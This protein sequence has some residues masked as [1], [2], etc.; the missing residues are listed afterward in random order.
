MVGAPSQST[1]SSAANRGT[2]RN[3][4]RL[5]LESIWST[6]LLYTS[7]QLSF[8]KPR[9]GIVSS[10]SGELSSESE[11]AQP[12]YWVEQARRTVHFERAMVS[13]GKLGTR[14]YLELGPGGVL[15]A[16]GAECLS[17]SVLAQSALVPLLRSNGEEHRAFLQALGQL[18]IH[19][20]SVDWDALLRPIKPRQVDVPT[21]PFERQ[22][23]WL[24]APR[25]KEPAVAAP[26]ICPLV[27]PLLSFAL[28]LADSDGCVFAGLLSTQTDPWLLEHS[29]YSVPI[30]SLIHI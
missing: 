22:R 13:L 15:C 26:G 10:T 14:R 9:I 29:I 4:P 8:H 5:R 7:A 12:A 17:D 25:R 30:L 28:P 1:G 19:G 24:D 2:R 16:L 3:E 27:H 18:H 21:Y 11:M 20:Q 23:C 6:C